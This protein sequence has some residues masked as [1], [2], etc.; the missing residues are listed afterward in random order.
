LVVCS[1]PAVIASCAAAN[2]GTVLDDAVPF[3]G[4][5]RVAAVV[6][7][8]DDAAAVQSSSLVGAT[9][10]GA[11]WGAREHGRFKASAD[12]HV[13]DDANVLEKIV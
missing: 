9:A 10:L 11:E 3:P 7:F 13:W 6:H 12:E 5:E 2:G 1:T 8:E 4:E